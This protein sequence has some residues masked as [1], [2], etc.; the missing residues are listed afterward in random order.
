MHCPRPSRAWACH[1]MEDALCIRCLVFCC[2]VPELGLL[3]NVWCDT[4]RSSIRPL[5]PRSTASDTSTGASDLGQRLSYGP[6]AALDTSAT[7]AAL[8]ASPTQPL[9]PQLAAQPPPQVESP[10]EIGRGG[11]AGDSN[12]CLRSN[13]WERRPPGLLSASFAAENRCATTPVAN[14]KHTSQKIERGSAK[15]SDRR[16]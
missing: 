5:P 12:D 6:P 3:T 8:T 1:A 11:P 4:C 10:V 15:W 16:A 7:D 13:S 9:P 14:L 2:C